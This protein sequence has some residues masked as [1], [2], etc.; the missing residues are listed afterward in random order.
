MAA[1]LRDPEAL[2][3]ANLERHLKHSAYPGRGLVVGRA[4]GGAGWLLVYWIM[5]RS[6]SSRARRFVAEGPRLRTEP[7][8][9]A[10]IRDAALVIYDAMLELPGL[11][12]VG[13]G[14]QV[15]TARDHLAAGGRFEDALAT[16]A[17]EPDAPNWTPRITALLDL[18]GSPRLALSLLKASPADPAATDRFSYRPAAPPPGLGLGLTTY[19]GDG[20]P[21]PSFE[22]EPLWLPVE[23]SAEAT[24]DRY[25]DALDPGNRVAL[26]VKHVAPHG[27]RIVLRNRFG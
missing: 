7:T 5:G 26:A 1:P 8:D 12:L 20:D 16:R 17:H 18:R 15:R 23:A 2:A 9:P 13:N 22:G 19:R 4:R 24:L 6:P 21:L 25:W 11:Q 10:K 3:A 14:D 27:S